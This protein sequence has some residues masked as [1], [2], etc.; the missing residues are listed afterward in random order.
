MSFEISLNMN[1]RIFFI[2]ASAFVGNFA[3]VKCEGHK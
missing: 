2:M 1:E 3:I